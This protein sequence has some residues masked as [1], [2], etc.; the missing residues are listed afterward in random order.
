MASHRHHG[1]VEFAALATSLRGM[2]RRLTER[3]DAVSSFAAHVSHEL[4]SPLSA[5]RGSAELL[6]DDDPADPMAPDERRRF[7]DHLLADT[8]RLGALLDRLREIDP[9][10]GRAD[11]GPV[12]AAA[13]ARRARR[14]LPRPVRAG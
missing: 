6:R 4:K 14:P 8:E 2:A 1:T 9:R 13:R 10:R 5:I 7:L 11:G 12:D 3:S